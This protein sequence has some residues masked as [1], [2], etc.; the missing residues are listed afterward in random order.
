MAKDVVN[1]PED[2]GEKSLQS[3]TP[4]TSSSKKQWF[5]FLNV[6]ENVEAL[7]P[8]NIYDFVL[9]KEYKKNQN[10]VFWTVFV[11]YMVYYIT[12]KQWTVVGSQLMANGT[13]G[14]SEYA[15]IGLIFSIAY[16]VSKFVSSPLSDT[17]SNKWLL[18]LGLIGA[19]IINFLLGLSWLQTVPVLTPIIL[20]CILMVAI[21]WVHSFGATPSVRFFYNWFPNKSRRNRIISWNVAHNIGSAMATFIILGSFTLFSEVFG[22]L[23][24]F[25]LPSIISLVMGVMVIILLKDTPESVGLPPLKEYYKMNLIGEKRQQQNK[26]VDESTKSWSYF[27]VKYILKNKFVWFL[28]ISN[29]LIYTLRMGLSDWSLMFL[30]DVHNYDMKKE[31]KWI[32]SMFDWGGL[33]FTLIIGLLANKYLKHFVPLT[34]GVISIATLALVGIWLT[35]GLKSIA[36][37]VCFMLLAGF[38]FIPQCFLPIMV[39]EFSH[40]KV[41]STAGGVLGI[42]GYLGDALMSKVIIGFGL[43]NVSWNAVFIFLIACGC[44]GAVI[45]V[46]M[47]KEQVSQ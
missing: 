13:I 9:H 32:Y 27:F 40:H 20:S 25:I 23:S 43:I 30:K 21:G 41:V 12:R 18:G 38:I 3:Q 2:G 7:K 4:V 44:L 34:I 24:Y 10:I 28:A 14:T 46:P 22:T 45:L 33:A 37:L 42:A 5:K 26:G 29:L 16:G 47:M 1:R 15:L 17:K 19:G 39:S 11:S 36:P 31:G 6:K 8:E 35:G